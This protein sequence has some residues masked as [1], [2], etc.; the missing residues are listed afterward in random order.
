MI[1]SNYD[2]IPMERLIAGQVIRPGG[3][4]AGLYEIVWVGEVY[5]TYPY[6]RNRNIIETKRQ[7][8]LHSQQTGHYLPYEFRNIGGGAVDVLKIGRIAA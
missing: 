1:N 5:P 3:R 2:H 4:Y 8:V 6:P 7:A